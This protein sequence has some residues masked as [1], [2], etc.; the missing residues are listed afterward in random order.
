MTAISQP[1]AAAAKKSPYTQSAF[2]C[3]V[4][5]LLAAA[6]GLNIAVAKLRL[7]F[8]KLPVPL[9]RPL[10]QIP[11]QMGDWVQVSRDKPLETD[12]QEV[13]GTDEYIFRDYL[14]VPAQGGLC[15]ALLLEG[16][17]A[18]DKDKDAADKVANLR[19]EFMLAT[20]ADRI[21]ILVRELKDK[22]TEQRETALAAVQHQFPES[23]VNMAVTY[24][25]GMADTVAHIP[26]RCYI[27][28]G[29][30]PTDYT[31]PKWTL[32]GRSDAL[33][34]RFINFQDAGD[35]L[36]PDRSVAYFFQ[37][38][39]SYESDPLA[40]RR[41]LQNLL[42]KYGYYAKVELMTLDPDHDRSAR[43]MV[44]FLNASLPEVERSFP[45]WKKVHA[46]SSG[47]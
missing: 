15:G 8:K 22:S 35:T 39:G 41:S 44:G 45:D 7:H 2:V 20:P 5:V 38:N 10:A 46:A 23:V 47:S 34:V 13:L 3:T 4:V 9:A 42:E 31:E 21:Q 14:Y 28:D 27:A 25:T 36:R 33:Q 32:A 26:D 37:C 12:V 11:L 30:E 16:L 18:N 29:Y 19:Q 40:V 24:Y 1:I 6:L 43:T 17:H